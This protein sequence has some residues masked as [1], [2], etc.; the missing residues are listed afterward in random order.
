MSKFSCDTVR[1]LVKSISRFARN[2]KECLE[3]VRELRSIGVTVYF[4]EQRI[5]IERTVEKG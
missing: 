4:E 1:V 5:E 3:Y 2:T